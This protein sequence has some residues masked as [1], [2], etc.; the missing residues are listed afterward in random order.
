MSFLAWFMGTLFIVSMS[1]HLYNL[2]N[3][4][5]HANF[6]IMT[7]MCLILWMVAIIRLDIEIGK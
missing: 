2:I 4:V 6:V 1:I 3:V 5:E 7:L